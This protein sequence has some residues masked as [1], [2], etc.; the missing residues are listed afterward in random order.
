MIGAAATGRSC[1]AGLSARY[2]SL[3]LLALGS[4]CVGM[5]TTLEPSPDAKPA[6]ADASI[7]PDPE[8]DR[9]AST[10]L[11]G[12]ARD[13][14]AEVRASTRPDGPLGADLGAV[15]PEVADTARREAA[16]PDAARADAPLA[17]ARARDTAPPPA[18]APVTGPTLTVI[19]LGGG[20]G[21]VTSSPAGIDCGSACTASFAGATVALTARTTNGADAR[22]AGWGGACSGLGRTCT[23]TVTVPT[24][25]TA[26]FAP[27][28]HNLVFLSSVSTFMPDLGGTAAYD[29]QCNELATAAGINNAQG[30]AYIAWI[31][32]SHS[33]ARDRLGPARGFVRMDGE[34]VADDPDAL[35]QDR[36]IYN[37]II[38]D[39]RGIVPA[40]GC[41]VL[42]GMDSAGNPS[43]TMSC[44]DWTVASNAA[45][46]TAGCSPCGP[47]TWYFWEGSTCDRIMGAL[48]CFGT[49]KTAPLTITPQSGRK[50]FVTNGPV[51][52]DQSA[53]ALCDAAK[54]AGS[55]AVVAL[56]AT[57][58]TPA[59]AFIDPA[60]AYVRPDGIVVGSG[61]DLI[62][63]TLRSGVWQQG[64]GFYV[65]HAVWT[66]SRSPSALG[67]VASTCADWTST[68]GDIYAGSTTSID[69]LWWQN[70]NPWTC[71]STYTW[72]YC[73]E[74]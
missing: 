66:G 18:D 25:V 68:T 12:V 62:A 6:S 42:T 23:V 7:P 28:E 41:R 45:T 27:L 5:R 50:L 9:R 39:E 70:P 46:V 48:Y 51:T 31:S 72:S 34:P 17:D 54:P 14:P 24:T 74:Q 29:R 16:V 64:N 26:E 4:G 3:L 49:T 56:R 19:K 63:G 53:D 44:N 32:D 13:A 22:F 57:T 10:D 33:S 40:G 35:V 36:Q 71:A 20:E 37:P 52:I 55:G 65:N 1:Y 47:V 59:S 67:T 15:S 2:A 43:P 61:E 58:T 8:A 69:G 38:V 73:I 30:D 60:A 21:T 11:A